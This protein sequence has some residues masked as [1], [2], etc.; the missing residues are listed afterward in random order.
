[1]SK[2]HGLPEAEL[3]ALVRDGYQGKGL[4]GEL[5]RRLLE[6][7]RHEKLAKVH[8]NMLREN[9]EMKAICNSL[10]FTLSD[11]DREDNLILAE[12]CL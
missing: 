11:G 8:S 12:L 9:I 2:L 1:M 3:A 7:A 10:G 4:G 5:Y 6:I